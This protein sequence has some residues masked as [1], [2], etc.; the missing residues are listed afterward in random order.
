MEG[1]LNFKYQE[2]AWAGEQFYSWFQSSCVGAFGRCQS[3]HHHPGQPLLITQ[4]QKLLLCALN[5]TSTHTVILCIQSEVL[6]NR[7]CKRVKSKTHLLLHLGEKRK[8]TTTKKN[9]GTIHSNYTL[10]SQTNA[11][12]KLLLKHFGH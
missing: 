5:F 9:A 7:I 11:F 3:V 6:R 8:K 12:S 4:Q 1:S 2:P 10:R